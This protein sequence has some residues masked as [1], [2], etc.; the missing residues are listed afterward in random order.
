MKNYYLKIM[1]KLIVVLLLSAFAVNS[2]AIVLPG[3]QQDTTKHKKTQKDTARKDTT[4]KPP[5]QHR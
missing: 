5:R 4:K 1:K 2:F 3:M